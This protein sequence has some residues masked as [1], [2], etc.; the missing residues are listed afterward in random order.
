MFT[1]PPMLRSGDTIACISSSWGGPSC[2]PDRYN[3]GKKQLADAFGMN[4]IDTAYSCAAA[5]D[6]YNNPEKRAADL[7]RAFADP[8][9]KAIISTIGG[10]DSIRMLPYLN[11][12]II[13]NNP[14]IFMG[15][16][17]T[18][19]SHFACMAAGLRSF[20]GP[21]I[22]AGFGENGGLIPYMTESVR[23]TLF[24]ENPIGHIPAHQDGWTAE[25][26]HWGTPENQEK[27]RPRN[28]NQ[29]TKIIQG[30][31]KAT[32]HLMGGCVEVLEMLKGTYLWPDH[33]TW[34]GAILFLEVSEDLPPIS[35]FTYFMRNY[36]ATGILSRIAGIIMGRPPFDK[37]QLHRLSDYDD[38]LHKVV[39]D[40]AGLTTLPIM[41][42]MDFGHTDP[43]F[44][45]PYG[46]LAEIDCDQN[47]FS[48]LDHSVT[49]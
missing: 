8:K 18:T 13:K 38:A 33:K 23:K 11:L 5:D 3:I 20:Y 46:G 25:M 36:A 24:T 2:F 6:I 14:K 17:D 26:S 45:I 19:V 47:R 27:S 30:H 41:S 29:G 35:Q 4:V 44:I 31:G 21:A 15:Y 43:M 22:M 39:H 48:I 37:T 7:M 16:S 49:A 34:D 12:D 10:D 1:K 32:G 9:V 40:E 42:Q 28:A